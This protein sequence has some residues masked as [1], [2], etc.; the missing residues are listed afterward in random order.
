MTAGYRW[1]AAGRPGS[2][3]SGQDRHQLVQLTEGPDPV[4]VAVLADGA[5]GMAGG[6]EAADL[7]ISRAIEFCRRFAPTDYVGLSDLVRAVDRAVAA[8]RDAGR[9]TLGVVIV[10]PD[11]VLAVSVGDSEVWAMVG[12]VPV[13]LSGRRKHGSNF[14]IGTGFAMGDMAVWPREKLQAVVLWTDE[15]WSAWTG[16]TVAELLGSS[17]P[18]QAEALLP[19]PGH[20]D[21]ATVVLGLAR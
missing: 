18:P 19:A 15:A 5:G 14:E 13:V 21:D 2:A 1:S 9:T 12:D 3:G 7:A 6:V 10:R 17:P 8:D 20:D 4:E 11:E 16:D